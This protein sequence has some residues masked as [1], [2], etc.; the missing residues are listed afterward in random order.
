[1]RRHTRTRSLC[2][3]V[4]GCIDRSAVERSAVCVFARACPALWAATPTALFTSGEMNPQIQRFCTRGPP[5]ECLSTSPNGAIHEQHHLHRRPGGHRGRR[6]VI[7][8]SALG[9]VERALSGAGQ[10]AG[11]PCR[12]GR[13]STAATVLCL[14]GA[15]TLA[16]VVRLVETFPGLIG[17]SRR[18]FTRSWQRSS[19]DRHAT[20]AVEQCMAAIAVSGHPRN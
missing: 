19:E 15:S 16:A 14:R 12:S 13:P 6:L 4:N 9:F 20:F 3:A 8:W 10:S 18:Q 2:T 7:F 5:L 1:M 11:L 17:S